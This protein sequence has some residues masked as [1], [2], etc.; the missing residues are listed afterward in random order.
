[1]RRHATQS[2]RPDQ[3]RLAIAIGGKKPALTKLQALAAVRASAFKR[4]KNRCLSFLADGYELPGCT[5]YINNVQDKT[6]GLGMIRATG[7]R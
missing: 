6:A 4:L 2:R 5:N 3:D 1:V 7:P